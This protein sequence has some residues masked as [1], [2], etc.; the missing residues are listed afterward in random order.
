MTRELSFKNGVLKV[1]DKK[2]AMF[3]SYNGAEGD[4]ISKI[5][6]SLPKIKGLKRMDKRGEFAFDL[7]Y[8]MLEKGLIISK[9]NS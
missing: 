7:Y 3:L 6:D 9:E 2:L 4:I 5:C 1:T 8:T